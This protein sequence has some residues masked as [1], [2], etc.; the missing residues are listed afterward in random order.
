LSDGFVIPKGTT[1]GVPT[2]AISMDPDLFDD[3]ETFD[4]FRFVKLRDGA[5]S[6]TARFQYA[7][8]T[9]TSMAFGYGRHACPGRFFASNEIKMIMAYL[10]LNYDFE[11]P[12]GQTER[13]AS[14]P[15]ET[16]YLPNPSAKVLLRK[17][18]S[19]LETQVLAQ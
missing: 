16:Q 13:P 19:H 7:A 1:I 8:S 18:S 2:Q 5:K 15:F 9:L 17:R 10:L 12:E 4:A 6:D 14:L 11:F 3:P